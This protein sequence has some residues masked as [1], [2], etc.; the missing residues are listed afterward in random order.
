MYGPW[1]KVKVTQL[2]CPL[3]GRARIKV[4][5]DHDVS[6]PNTLVLELFLISFIENIIRLLLIASISNRSISIS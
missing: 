2:Q 1:A 6:Y 5:S 4:Y 3:C